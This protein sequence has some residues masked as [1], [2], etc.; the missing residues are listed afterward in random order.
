[1]LTLIVA[2]AKNGA[3]GRA[4]TI[5]VARAR[6]SGRLPTRN[7]GRRA[8][9][10]AA[11]MG[12]PAV[13]PAEEP[14]EH[15]RDLRRG[16]VGDHRPHARGGAGHRQAA[17]HSRLYGIGGSAIYRAL[18]PLAHR[19]LVTEV[20]LTI[21]DADAF[22]PEFDQAEWR[23][24][25]E[26][27]CARMG[28]AVCCGNGCGC[29][30]LKKRVCMKLA[31][32]VSDEGNEQQSSLIPQFVPR[33][34]RTFAQALEARFFWWLSFALWMYLFFQHLC[35]KSRL[36]AYAEPASSTCLDR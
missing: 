30:L 21:P 6:G 33:N 22:F 17:G 36:L 12:K 35:N 9:H 23:K 34:K 16:P 28:R 8:D 13:P 2:R 29:E 20:D 18:L 32:K 7:H 1:M 10:G 31:V 27:P 14:V 24:I 19:L 26:H 11:H 4:N 25:W 15:R 5:P 3:I